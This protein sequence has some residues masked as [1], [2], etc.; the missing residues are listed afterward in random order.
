MDWDVDASHTAQ[1][2]EAN[3]AQSDW[4][5]DTDDDSIQNHHT[6][7]PPKKPKVTHHASAVVPDDVPRQP[8]AAMQ[9]W[10]PQFAAS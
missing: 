10:P 3:N 7:P 5:V 6:V 2:Q 9:D 4:D 8:A 1:L